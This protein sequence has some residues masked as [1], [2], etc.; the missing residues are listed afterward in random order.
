LAFFWAAVLEAR[1]EEVEIL[2]KMKFGGTSYLASMFGRSMVSAA[3]SSMQQSMS[4]RQDRVN[5]ED[6]NYPPGLRVI[7]FNI[8]DVEV[9]FACVSPTA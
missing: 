5:W 6:F 2:G 9:S 3:A 8:L 7:H 4:M 1:L